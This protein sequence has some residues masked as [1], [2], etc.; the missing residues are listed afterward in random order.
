MYWELEHFH[1]FEHNQLN[2]YHDAYDMDWLQQEYYRYMSRQFENE[3]IAFFYF[4]IVLRKTVDDHIELWYSKESRLH[5]N[6][7]S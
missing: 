3:I 6:H 2:T 7:S 1:I 5:S 4:S